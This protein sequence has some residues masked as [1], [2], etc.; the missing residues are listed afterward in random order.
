MPISGPAFFRINQVNISVGPEKPIIP[1]NIYPRR[2]LFFCLGASL[3]LGVFV[4]RGK[5]KFE[6]M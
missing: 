3:F 6:K 5:S 2:K 1:V 4:R